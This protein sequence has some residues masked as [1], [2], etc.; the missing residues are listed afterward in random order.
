MKGLKVYPAMIGKNLEK[1]GPFAGTEA[2]M[3]KLVEKGDDRQEGHEMIRVH[4]FKAWDEVMKDRP[5][6]LVGMLTGDKM[7]SSK[8]GAAE[9][10]KLLD[11]RHHTGDAE[12]KCRR[13]V[14]D[15]IDPVLKTYRKKVGISGEVEY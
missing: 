3:M 8:L 11:P 15:S 2:V 10:R 5:N 12:S 13:L 6:P 1:F 7:I 14:R 4:S 9:V